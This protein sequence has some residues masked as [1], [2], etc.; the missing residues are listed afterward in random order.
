MADI[1]HFP[2]EPIISVDSKEVYSLSVITD[3]REQMSTNI[4]W[5][6]MYLPNPSTMGCIWHMVMFL[7]QS[8]VFLNFK[9]SFFLTRDREIVRIKSHMNRETK[10]I[11]K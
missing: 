2:L 3:T 7:K 11:K 6:L 1:I 9:F 8:I 10:I 5:L 4:S